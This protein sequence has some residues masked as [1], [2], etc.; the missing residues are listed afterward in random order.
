MSQLT[1]NAL[2]VKRIERPKKKKITPL[3]HKRVAQSLSGKAQPYLPHVTPRVPRSV[4][5]KFHA[6]WTKTKSDLNYKL[7]ICIAFQSQNK[8]SDIVN[9]ILV[10]FSIMNIARKFRGKAQIFNRER[11]QCERILLRNC[12]DGVDREFDRY[13][14]GQL[15]H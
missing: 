6:V 5:A 15:I 8:C 9:D 13:D 2:K 11:C 7:D 12:Q 3:T 14:G 1:R 4:H 10:M